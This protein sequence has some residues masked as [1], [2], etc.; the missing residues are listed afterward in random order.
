MQPNMRRGLL[1]WSKTG[2]VYA[3]NADYVGPSY[4]GSAGDNLK[5]KQRKKPKGAVESRAYGL[6]GYWEKQS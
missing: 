6:Y 3:K 1:F 4:T 2:V 5:N